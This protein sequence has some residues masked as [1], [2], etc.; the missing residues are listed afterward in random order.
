MAP[1]KS[2]T[3]DGLGLVQLLVHTGEELAIEMATYWFSAK[4]TKEFFDGDIMLENF[5]WRP[6]WR[7]GYWKILHWYYGRQGEQMVLMRGKHTLGANLERDKRKP[8]WWFV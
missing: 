3:V 1:T 7:S 8:P 4:V 2:L 5:V 6:P